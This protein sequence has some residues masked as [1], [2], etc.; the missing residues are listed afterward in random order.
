MK[1]ISSARL[2]E[3]AAFYLGTLGR[4]AAWKGANPFRKLDYTSFIAREYSWKLSCSR[5]S[6]LPGDLSEVA[7]LFAMTVLIARSPRQK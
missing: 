5:K 1:L 6:N 2:A 4:C 7:G 3:L